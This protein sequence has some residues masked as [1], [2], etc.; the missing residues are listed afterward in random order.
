MEAAAA[1][2][3]TAVDL[4]R[5]VGAAWRRAGPGVDATTLAAAGLE[6]HVAATVAANGNCCVAERQPAP[7]GAGPK[8]GWAAAQ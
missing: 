2:A 3:E 4:Q 8:A 5:E 1:A 7:I 6:P